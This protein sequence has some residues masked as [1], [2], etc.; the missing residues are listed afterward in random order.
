MGV[1]VARELAVVQLP[2]DH[3]SDQAHFS[4]KGSGVFANQVGAFLER[5]GLL[6]QGE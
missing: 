1:A 5:E 3:F 2:N 6:Q 4:P